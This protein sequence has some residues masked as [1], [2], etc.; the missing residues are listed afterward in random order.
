MGENDRQDSAQAQHEKFRTSHDRA[1]AEHDRLDCAQTDLQER[2]EREFTLLR[3]QAAA[4]EGLIA[5]TAH[6]VETLISR[7]PD[8]FANQWIRLGLEVET[9]GR[10][11][12]ADFV[13][14]VEFVVLKTE[15]D[16]IKKL[17]YGFILTVLACFLGGLLVM[18]GWR[19]G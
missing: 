1:Q 13:K 11:I 3:G 14:R 8:D 5:T 4:H 10:K 15:H 16:Q 12:D 19:K 7:I 2:H 18:L 9:I 17:V 6:L